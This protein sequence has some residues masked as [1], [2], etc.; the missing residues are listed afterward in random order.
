MDYLEIFKFFDI[1][2][3]IYCVFS[4]KAL[5]FEPISRL[6][7]NYICSH[8]FFAKEAV[9]LMF[10]RKLLDIVRFIFK[11]LSRN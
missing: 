4:Q 7:Q 5:S 1:F 6:I 2:F 10:G 11:N 3:R 8:T 9:L